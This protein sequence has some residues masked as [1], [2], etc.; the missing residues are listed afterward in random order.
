MSVIAL[1]L[2]EIWHRKV[3]YVLAVLAVVMAVTLYIGFFTAGKASERE[4]AR[5]MLSMGYNMHIIAKEADP[6]VFL[7]GEDIARHGGGFAVTRGLVDLFGS[8]RVRDTPIS[9]GA[10]TGAAVGAATRGFRPIAEIMYIDFT[11]VAMDQICNQA[12]KMHYMFGGKMN[13]PVVIRTPG[14]SGG[15]GRPKALPLMLSSAKSAI[16]ASLGAVL[17]PLP[18]LSSTRAARTCCHTR[19]RARKSLKRLETT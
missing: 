4:T 12:A 10:I 14:G 15:R 5:L 9:E 13:V 2:K 3:N 6:N 11:T 19:D 7:I 16:R 1:I 17:K 8:E 18:T